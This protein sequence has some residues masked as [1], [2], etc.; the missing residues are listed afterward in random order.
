MY[1]ISIIVPVFQVEN[2]IQE[3]LES[4]VNQTLDSI[5]IVCVNDGS[6]DNSL[7]IIEEYK[8]RFKFIRLINQENQGLSGARNTGLK[9]ISGEYLLFVDGD[10][11]LEPNVLASIY[12]IASDN[13][14]DILDFYIN[15]VEDNIKRIWKNQYLKIDTPIT[16]EIYF[17]KYIKQFRNQP[18]V[19]AWSHLYRTEFIK[20]NHLEFIR[21]RYYEDIPFTA[22]AY[23]VAYRVYFTDIQVYNYRHNESSIT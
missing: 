4:L 23:L 7:K 15:S 12:E 8:R 16:G 11:F 3:C 17:N 5:E 1:K 9:H 2:F 20:Q 22:E 21:D 13:N 6:Y 14:L 18:P 10:D 19:S